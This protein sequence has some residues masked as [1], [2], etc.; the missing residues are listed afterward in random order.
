MYCLQISYFAWHL[1]GESSGP[2]V[3]E[4]HPHAP[5][6]YSGTKGHESTY[7]TIALFPH[8]A[9]SPVY[10]QSIAIDFIICILDYMGE[11]K[12]KRKLQGASPSL[13]GPINNVTPC[14]LSD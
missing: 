14:S 3:S 6:S 13:H 9:S 7:E 8:K 2:R 1:F 4:E 10:F 5:F 12:R 11:K